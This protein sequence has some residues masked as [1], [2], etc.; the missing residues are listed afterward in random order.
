MGEAR[1]GELPAGELSKIVLV[2]FFASYLVEKRELLSMGTHQVAGMWVP[3]VRHLG[4]IVLAW[5]FSLVI[6]FFEKDLGSSLLFFALFITML[7]VATARGVYLGIGGIMFALG[8]I[9]AYTL[10]DHVRTR[11]SI[12][13]DPWS[14]ANDAGYQTMQAMFA[15]A[16]GGLAGANLG[17]GSPQ[18]IPAVATDFIFA[19][20]GEEL[21]LLGTV[22]ILGGFLLMVG[23]GLRIAMRAEPPFEKLLAAGLTAILGIQSFIILGG[24]T[25]LVPLTGITL[26]FVSYGGSSLISNYILLALLLRISDDQAQRAAQAAGPRTR[27]SWA[28]DERTWHEHP[29]PHA[30]DRAHG[31]V[32]RPVRPAQQP[33]GHQ[34]QQ[35]QQ[36]PAQHPHRGPRLL[37]APGVIQT[38]DGVVIAES[39]EV[40]DAFER[41]RRYPEGELFAHI[42]GYFSFT[43]GNEGV[44]RTYNDALTGRD[45]KVPLDRLG[46]ILLDKDKT[47]NVTL[48]V[49]KALQQIATDG[50]AGR[51]GSVVAIDPR[52][53]AILAFADYPTYDPNVLASHNQDDVR[54]A[55]ADL[56]ADEDRPL[57]PRTYRE[58]Y[59][60]G[61][62]FKVVTAAAAL[63]QGVATLASPSTPSSPS[64]PCPSRSSPC[65]TSGARRA[66]GPC[67]R[68]S[69]SRATPPSPRWAST[70]GR[71]ACPGGPTTSGST[72]SRPSTCPSGRSR[73]SPTPA[74][75]PGTSRPWPS[76]PS[77]SRTCRPRPCRWPWWRPA[78][79][80][81]A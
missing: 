26:P 65:A 58:R 62:S 53:G 3:E 4:P 44:E 59:F 55:W 40:D 10:F 38:S 13:T 68:S 73:C 54:K 9:L 76:R 35:P 37:P 24:V 66:A 12:W 79:P 17:Q 6:M 19:A 70:W 7:W 61:S 30:R 39:V 2:V 1:S 8:A 25:R 34:R 27:P 72:R 56:N 57:L 42:T 67:P 48:T 46:D 16:A 11:I 15:F 69:G 23:A 60:P 49:S 71:R 74:P 21:G 63:A 22:A 43:F 41:Q 52:N 14:V 18:R 29:D 36:P 75:S 5:S 31:A 81:T 78:S 20:I 28:P 51:K 45:R 33:P 77:A 50:L 80:T 47:A 64:C 32:L